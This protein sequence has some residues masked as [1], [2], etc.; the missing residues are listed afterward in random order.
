MRSALLLVLLA[1]VGVSAQDSTTL[2]LTDPCIGT[3][4][5]CNGIMQMDRQGYLMVA[6][7][8]EPGVALDVK[9]LAEHNNLLLF[10]KDAAGEIRP[11]SDLAVAKSEIADFFDACEP[12]WPAGS[13]QLTPAVY[14]HES[15]KQR[16]ISETRER[17]RKL[18]KCETARQALK[19]AA[20]LLPK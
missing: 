20:G 6:M 19:R 11:V 5:V 18:E 4:G 13:V 17:L 3:A 12:E 2:R 14:L 8:A 7:K 9:K 16:E 15:P 1:S 10:Y